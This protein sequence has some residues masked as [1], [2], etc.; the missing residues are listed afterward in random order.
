[1]LRAIVGSPR[2]ALDVDTISGRQSPG[3]LAPETFAIG[4]PQESKH[5]LLFERFDEDGRRQ[6]MLAQGESLGSKSR[7]IVEG[8]DP[9]WLPNGDEFVFGAD[10][11]H[12]AIFSV[13][14][15]M[16]SLVPADAPSSSFLV[17]KAVSRDGRAL[18][19]RYMD[20]DSRKHVHVHALPSLAS[21]GRMVLDDNAKEMAWGPN[22]RLMVIWNDGRASS[23]AELDFEDAS[24]RAL[25]ILS[26]RYVSSP[27]VGAA[28]L[29]FKSV[30]LRGDA[31]N[32]RDG[33]VLSRITSDGFNFSVDRSEKGDL[34]AEHMG[35]D[36][37][38]RLRYIPAGGEPRFVTPG[39]SDFSPQFLPDGRGWLYVDGDTR[40]IRRCKE[41]GC[42]TVH[43][44]TEYPYFPAA[45]PHEEWI[46]YVTKV[47]R[48]RLIL[49]GRDGRTRDLGPVRSDCAPRWVDDRLLWILQGTDRDAT[50]VQI[51]VATGE[52]TGQTANPGPPEGSALGCPFL[53]EPPGAQHRSEVVVLSWEETDLRAIRGGQQP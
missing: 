7:R 22:N 39:P 51:D 34:I 10:S 36:H 14:L 41:T 28:G 18:A 40:S 37:K 43:H 48:P 4:C 19:L 50:W 11:V 16:K 29:A 5:G 23:L 30:V 15:M 33:R 52:K 1:V 9:L 47:G 31:W 27:S 6:I 20:G 21:V 17:D 25:G 46:A 24:A 42:E 3:S 45:S 8:S 13:P 38:V 49:L 53:V 44:A 26:D 2:R 35:P 12:A 32:Y